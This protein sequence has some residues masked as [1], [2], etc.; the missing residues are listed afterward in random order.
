MSFPSRRL[1]F[2]WIIPLAAFGYLLF[3]TAARLHRVDGV[4]NLV[5]T[6]VTLDPASAT[7]YAGGLRN[8]IVPAHNSDSYGWIMQ[9]QQ[10]LAPQGKWRIREVSYD[11]AP[12]GRTVLTPSLYRWWLGLLA[13]A[14]HA[15]SSRP[16]GLSVEHVARIADV[17]LQALFFVAVVAWVAWR[18]GAWPAGVLSVA[19]VTLFPFGGAFLPGQPSDEGLLS[20]V[21]SASLLL[22]LSGLA[23]ARSAPPAANPQATEVS[24]APA[25]TWF[26][27]AGIAGGIAFWLDAVRSL[28]AL[29]GIGLGGFVAII[30]TR[31]DAKPGASRPLLPWR[32]WALGGATTI[33]GGYLIEYFPGYLGTLN[34][35]EVHPLYGVVWLGLGE[36][37]T[38]VG[39]FAQPGERRWNVRH[40]AATIAAVLTMAALPVAIVM[41]GPRDLFT[42]DPAGTRLSHLAGGPVAET[43]WAWLWRDGI[44]GTVAATCLPTLLLLAAGG[45]LL[46]SGMEQRQRTMLAVGLGAALVPLGFAVFRL[47]EWQTV[48]A[49]LLGL[50]V[51]LAAAATHGGRPRL[52]L[53]AL[54][55]AV[56]LV[57][58]P[59]AILFTKAAVA[60]RRDP[61]TGAEVTALI[62][63]D[64]AHWLARQAGPGGAVVLAPPDLTASLI[65]HGG[66][67]GIG[68][69]SWENQAG[70]LAAMRIASASTADEALAVAQ[71]R[72]LGY[73]VMPSWDNFLEEYARLGST[74]PQRSLVSLLEHWRP[75]R[76]LRPVP[77]H[78]PQVAGFEDQSVAVFRVTEV[79]DNATALSYLAEYFIE[80]DRIRDAMAVAETLRRSYP[81]DLGAIVAR[82]LAAK[83]AEDAPA[84][85]QALADLEASLARGDSETLAWDR[86]VSLA[87][88]LIEGRRLE[89]ARQEA[90]RCIDEIDE[91]RLRSLTTVSLHRLLVMSRTFGLQIEKPQLYSLAQQLLPA[92]LRDTR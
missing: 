37:L 86:R 2:S 52:R 81:T 82:V 56:L 75:P 71:A 72:N 17:V 59:G 8:L 65:Y 40:I 88:A 74:D 29:A 90:K 51:A 4:T 67:S 42:A 77:Y 32:H 92:G 50:L 85:E 15:F 53:G 6:E 9:T 80:M 27:L 12:L 69:P 22:L 64:L 19:L 84:F 13:H 89:Q 33:L 55:A 61:A 57:L 68:T 25:S 78:L 76:W 47:R 5:E 30:S 43:F 63:R 18:F 11:N 62:D 58:T 60:D 34:L 7:G 46:R 26:L 44:T 3:L 41:A 10:M 73:I 28:P 70:F 79:Q 45:L 38:R 16:V 48:D 31:R 20:L 91:P 49:M 14:D 83:A 87:V 24:S 54:V 21:L 39:A 23:P 35:R 36:L 66:L 1:L